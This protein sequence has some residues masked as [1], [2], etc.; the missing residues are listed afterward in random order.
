MIILLGIIIGI[1][2]TS[3]IGGIV[4]LEAGVEIRCTNTN[5]SLKIEVDKS[6]EPPVVIRCQ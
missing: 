4:R 5:Q 2:A 3:T 6:K 1:G